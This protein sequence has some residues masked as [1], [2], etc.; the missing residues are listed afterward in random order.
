[1]LAEVPGTWAVIARLLYGSGLRVSEALRL[2]VKDFDFDQL[3]VTVHC[4]KGKKSRLV[5]LPRNLVDPLKKLMEE[6]RLM[7]DADL[8]QGIASVWM[9]EALDRKMPNAKRELRWQFLFAS[10]KFS[11]NPKTGRFH[12]HH[13][14]RDSFAAALRRA[15]NRSG[16]LK[17]IT[18]HTFRHSF[19]THMLQ[20]GTDIRTVQELLGH[21]DV[22]TTMIYTHVLFNESRPVCSPL[23]LLDG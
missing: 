7:H 11:K 14:H 22:S 15:A 10:G 5:P 16:I 13:L 17:Y 20:A 2:R 1:M 18:S 8:A 4:S 21:Q 12:R 6:R 3:Q 23:D 9:P 19:A